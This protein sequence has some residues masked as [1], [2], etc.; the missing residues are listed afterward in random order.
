MNVRKNGIVSRT[1]A[2]PRHVK[3]HRSYTVEEEARLF[4]IHKN[5]VRSWLK[6]G[7]EVN[8]AKRPVLILGKH[9]SSFLSDRR[10]KNK[11]KCA[12]G[13]LYCVRC[14][15]PKAAAGQ[16]AVYIPITATLGNLV[17]ICPDCGLMMNRRVSLA[18]LELVKT[19]LAITL[20]QA[21]PS[22]NESQQPTVSSDLRRGRQS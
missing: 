3:I 14:R 21:L 6:A 11:R 20:Q 9:L 2:S 19:G 13:E 18:G 17:A 7:L 12:A 15:A 4:G 1:R 10:I 22:I 16:M 5:T 8:D